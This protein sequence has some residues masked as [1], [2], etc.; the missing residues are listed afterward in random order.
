MRLLVTRPEPDAARTADKLRA[1]GHAV[2]LAPLMR[3][4][5]VVAALAGNWDA[6]LMTSANAARTISGRAEDLRGLPVFAVGDKTAEAARDAGFAQVTSADGAISDLVDLVVAQL[7]DAKERLLYLTGEDR[8]GDL[9]GDL[10][11]HGHVIRTAVVYRV[12][13]AD[14]LPDAVREAIRAGRLDAVLHY[15]R[16]SAATLLRLAADAGVLN[17]ALSLAHYC[18]SEEVAAPLRERGASAVQVAPAPQEAALIGV[19]GPA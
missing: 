19:L 13:A 8:A 1:A 2:L 9:A 17:A 14:S 4:E 16:R 10:A 3:V 15:S 6:V 5:P 11:R 12:V 18:L 7:G